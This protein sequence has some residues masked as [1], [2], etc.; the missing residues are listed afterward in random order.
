MTQIR[1]QCQSRRWYVD[2]TSRCVA[3]PKG[4]PHEVMFNE[5]DHTKP[6]KGDNA[7]RYR[8]RRF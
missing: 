7:Y 6:Y 8:Y 4:I 2:G 5:F 3:F 1:P